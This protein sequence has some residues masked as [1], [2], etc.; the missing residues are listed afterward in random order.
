VSL[1]K[2]G[3]CLPGSAL[4]VGRVQNPETSQFPSQ[5]P[6]CQ[7]IFADRKAGRSRPHCKPSS[8]SNSSLLLA[9]T[10]GGWPVDTRG[11]VM[12]EFEC[13]KRGPRETRPGGP[14][15]LHPRT[16]EAGKA[17]GRL[18]SAN[19]SNHG[20]HRRCRGHVRFLERKSSHFRPGRG[21]SMISVHKGWCPGVGWASVVGGVRVGGGGEWEGVGGAVRPFSA[22]PW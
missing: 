16:C 7:M 19:A 17:T 1:R 4:L 12:A 2:A 14:S 22:G 8:V 3:D 20:G 11:H 6:P 15:R 18:G 13:G 10:F 5:K 21:V 9:E